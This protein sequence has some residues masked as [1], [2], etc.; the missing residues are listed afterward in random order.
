MQKNV[1]SKFLN[2][3]KV[4]FESE[5]VSRVLHFQFLDDI[6]PIWL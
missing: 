3:Q 2:F 4:N 1:N 5:E 6:T